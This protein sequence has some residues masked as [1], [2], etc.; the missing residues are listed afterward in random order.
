MQSPSIQPLCEPC[1][2]RQAS[3]CGHFSKELRGELAA[4][5]YLRAFRRGETVQAEG[6]DV[7][8]VG[9]VL[10]GM[11]RIQTTIG[12][13]RRR[14]VGLLMPSDFFGRA[15][16]GPSRVA[17]GAASD[18][19][20]CCFERGA[21]ESLSG[22]FPQLGREWMHDSLDE[23]DAA[24]DWMVLLDSPSVSALVASFLLMLCRR[25]EACT[26]TPTGRLLVS[27]PISRSDM[28]AYLGTTVET[29]GRTMRKMSS[30]NIIRIHEPRHFEVL[31]EARLMKLSSHEEL[32]RHNRVTLAIAP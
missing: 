5:S 16:T 17:I 19:I 21:F 28:A 25:T 29:I 32:V 22:R 26:L 18:A 4:I 24:R 14:L 10:S 1:A 15:L 31:D 23:I 3:S 9:N 6:E 13:G 2:V 7:A 12:D 20:V 11:L 30:L 8:F 27:I